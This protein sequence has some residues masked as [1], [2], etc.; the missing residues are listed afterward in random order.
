M[1]KILF[2]S[3][4]LTLISLLTSAQILSLTGFGGYTFRDKIN[5]GNA[6]GYLNA[7]GHW[8]LSVEGIKPSGHAIELLF[9]Q[10]RTHTPLYYYA[11]PNNQINTNAD[12]T[13]IS[14]LM[15]NGVRY[16]MMPSVQP[17][18]GLGLG[19]AF[20]DNKSYSSETKFA[21][22]AKLGVKFKASPMIGIKLQAQLFSV[23]QAA[24]GGFYYGTGGS[25]V[26]ISSYSS[27][28]QFG[29]SGGICLDFDK[30]RMHH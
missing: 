18:F 21:W 30:T 6:Y 17:Y 29:F 15:L 12:Q 19:A 3:A 27:I 14:Y 4:A 25:A 24:G 1:K 26:V 23:I 16:L 22:D 28:Y 10:Q 11:L 5:F 7:A 8:G 2:L 13:T 9:Q 20:I